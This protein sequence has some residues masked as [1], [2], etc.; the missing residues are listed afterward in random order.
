[1]NR[2]L[3]AR[4]D[5]IRISTRSLAGLFSMFLHRWVRGANPLTS[6]ILLVWIVQLPCFD[7]ARIAGRASRQPEGAL[8][9]CRHLRWTRVE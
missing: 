5:F 8:E 7:P 3:P 1:M 4:T 9:I 6:S 2:D